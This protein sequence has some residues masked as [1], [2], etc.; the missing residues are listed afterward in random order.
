MARERESRDIQIDSNRPQRVPLHEQKRSILTASNRDP[1]YV[2]R[3]VNDENN[4]DHS[5][6]VESFKLAGYEVVTNTNVKVGDVDGNESL[7]TGAVASVGGGKKAILMRI[8]KEH[9]EQD[10]QVKQK[11]ITDQEKAMLG[12]KVKATDSDNDGT[13]GETTL[14]K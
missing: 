3:F 7:G 14:T 13:Y 12:R 9:Y 11:Q 8:K 2:Y 1:N 5:S 6:R 4:P 10:Q